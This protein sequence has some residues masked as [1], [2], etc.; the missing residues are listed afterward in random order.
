MHAPLARC[1]FATLRASSESRNTSFTARA[2]R[3]AKARSSS[4]LRCLSFPRA[5]TLRRHEEYGWEAEEEKSSED[6]EAW[7]RRGA[8]LNMFVNIVNTRI[9]VVNMSDCEVVCTFLSISVGFA[10]CV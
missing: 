3:F 10:V 6:E 9:A 2:S 4:Q 5:T 1:G 8:A 7:M